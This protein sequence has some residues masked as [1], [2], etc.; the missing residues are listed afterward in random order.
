MG[1]EGWDREERKL[2]LI[3]WF[4]ARNHPRPQFIKVRRRK[5]VEGEKGE[6]KW[7]V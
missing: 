5:E 6:E 3:G 2:T 1:G 7:V 4:V